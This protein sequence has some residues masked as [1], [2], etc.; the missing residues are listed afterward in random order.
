MGDH[1]VQMLDLSLETLSTRDHELCRRVIEMDDV[2]D[3]YDYQIEQSC[4]RL[5]ALQQPMSKDLRIIGT[6]LKII[7]DLERIGDFAVD[8]AKTARR[9]AGE[10]FRE[11]IPQIRDM[12][13]MVRSVVCEALR[14]Y[15]RS[16]LE[17]VHLAIEMDDQVDRCYDQIFTELLEA[18]EADPRIYREAVWYTHV[19][20]FLER[21]ADH[22]VNVAERVYYMVT[23]IPR[24]LA[25]SHGA[26]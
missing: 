15:V 4:L 24:Q 8:I 2:A 3:R 10:T 1:V 21:M 11:P 6:A 16:D 14:A 26:H 9:G 5:L 7:T 17:C 19:I 23:G 20:R 22:A 12:G 13:G 25:P 18:A